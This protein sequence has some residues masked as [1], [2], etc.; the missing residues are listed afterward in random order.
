MDNLNELFNYLN[1]RSADEID[2]LCNSFDNIKIEDDIFILT[3]N[4]KNFIIYRRSNC[5]LEFKFTNE[6]IPYIK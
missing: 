4:N 1:L 5:S 2:N 6:Y 3:K